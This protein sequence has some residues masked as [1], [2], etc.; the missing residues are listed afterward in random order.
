MTSELLLFYGHAHDP[1][2]EGLVLLGRT[3]D[4]TENGIAAITTNLTTPATTM[5]PYLVA[6]TS[7]ALLFEIIVTSVNP[8]LPR[9]TLVK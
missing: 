8:S 3:S 9:P 2:Q 5:V 6:L 1:V 7:S 4:V